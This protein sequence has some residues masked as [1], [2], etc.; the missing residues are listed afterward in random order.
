MM[1]VLGPGTVFCESPTEMYP[2][3][4]ELEVSSTPRYSATRQTCSL[5]LLQDD[6]IIFV[7]TYL[8]F[9]LFVWAYAIS[10]RPAP[11]EFALH[12]LLTK[13]SSGRAEAY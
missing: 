12:G 13:T 10:V 3:D 11:R 5:R 9:M 7:K 1:P 4:Y 8:F 6:D 2:E